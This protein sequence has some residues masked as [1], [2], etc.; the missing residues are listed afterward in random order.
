MGA[1]LDSI[2]QVNISIANAAVQ[3]KGFG[4]GLILGS[5]NRFTGGDLFR[6]YSSAA[7]MLSDSFLV[8][9]PEYK[10]A[11]AY[12]G[13]AISPPDVMVGY[14]PSDV[15]Q[16]ETLTPTAND[17]TLYTVTING[18]I[19]SFTSGSGATAAQIVTGLT[20]AINAQSPALPVVCS[21]STTLILTSANAGESFTVASS[22]NIAIAHTTPDTGVDTALT[23]I[24][25]Q[26]GKDWY[27]LIYTGRGQFDI[28]AAAAWIEAQTYGYIFLA[29]SQES[30]VL[31]NVTTDVLSVLQAASY[32][33]TAYLW[34]DDQAHFPDAA[35]IGEEFPK[36]PGSSNYS[37]KTLIGITPTAN[38]V[39]TDSKISIL[40]GKNGNYY[41]NVGG[42]G[43]T[44]KGKMAGG[45][46]IDVVV[47]RDWIK[48]T[49]QAAIFQVLVDTPKVGFDDAGIGLL[50][51][52]I[53]S[54]L[55]QA[56]NF[57]IIESFD[58]TV[59]LAS[60]FSSSQKSTRI[61]P[62]INWTAELVGAIDNIT[63]NGT[64]TA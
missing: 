53:R 50:C 49:M 7:A 20:N 39:L 33:R 18:I 6:I 45:Q 4:R 13:Q 54:V 46:W 21:G 11:L 61:L 31:T 60:S 3:Q 5:A 19:S 57:G 41:M 28:Q 42:V 16:V 55:K 26:G 59:P 34:S 8:T 64:L 47:G 44:Q 58:L 56:Q 63:I 22:A 43:V 38:S 27:G 37:Y 40:E 14:A 51:N 9:D 10:A 25:A 48:Y 1:T 62:S 52:A 17:T 24:V 15:A 36:Q 35:C 30:D 32:L 29:C 23:N 2:V 12:F